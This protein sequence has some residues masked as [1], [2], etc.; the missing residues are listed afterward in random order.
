[1][2]VPGPSKEAS[3][4]LDNEGLRIREPFLG[5]MHLLQF[6]GVCRV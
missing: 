5:L 6:G 4:L 3:M 2:L 1:M